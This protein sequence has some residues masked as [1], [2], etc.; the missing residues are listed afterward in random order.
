MRLIK[1]DNYRPEELYLNKVAQALSHPIRT[2]I[3]ELLNEKKT[4][5]R[6]ELCSYFNVTKVAMY[7][8]FQILK[9][10]DLISSYY[11]VHFEEIQLNRSAVHEMKKFL[12]KIVD[13]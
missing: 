7:N 4:Y 10:A 6:I 1:P 3:L 12:D 5:S 2:R 8:H 9:E 11:H 13:F